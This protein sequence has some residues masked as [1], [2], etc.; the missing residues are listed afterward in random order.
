MKIKLNLLPLILIVLL[1]I[2]SHSQEHAIT[3]KVV[4]GNNAPLEYVNAMLF[5]ADSS[6]IKGTVTDANGVFSLKSPQATA[7]YLKL[8]SLG[9]KEVIT[10]II[11]AT[12]NIQLGTIILENDELQL[13]E[14]VLTAEK[15]LIERRS[16]RLIVNVSNSILATGSNGLELLE[17]SPGLFI[18][19]GGISL[20]GRTG[21]I[22]Q[23]N[24][25]QQR[26]SS[27]ELNTYLQSI[28]SSQIERIE[29]IHNPSAA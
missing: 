27:T 22:I 12:S 6:F 14:V 1:P 24:G 18:E 25:R 26:L 21:L 23:I 19:D 20:R 5:K 28:P 7:A 9:F 29:I 13:E 11:S 10:P 8:Q 3:G 4:D 16:D 17:K 15:P 2:M